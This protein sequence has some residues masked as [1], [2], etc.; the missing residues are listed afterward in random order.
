MKWNLKLAFV[1]I[2][3]LSA[4]LFG[5]ER[6]ESAIKTL[7]CV[8]TL[9]LG[10]SQLQDSHY[11]IQDRQ[12]HGVDRVDFYAGKGFDVFPLGLTSDL[13]ATISGNTIA[14]AKPT[15]WPSRHGASTRTAMMN[16]ARTQLLS[17]LDFASI[18]S[19]PTGTKISASFHATVNYA[20]KGELDLI[21]TSGG[22][23]RYHYALD[24]Q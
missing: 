7:S 21:L 18:W 8:G 1:G 6:D 4:T 12:Y 24:C 15:I 17:H 16:I 2:T 3:L 22:F 20:G 11:Y 5:A 14:G 23:R 10:K 9:D 13:P 19:A